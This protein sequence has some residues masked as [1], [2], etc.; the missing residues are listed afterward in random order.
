MV[1]VRTALIFTLLL[2][3]AACSRKTEGNPLGAM[4][5]AATNSTQVFIVKGV[6]KAVK[7]GGKIMEIRHETIPDYMPAMTMPFDVKNPNEV[8]NLKPGDAISF[9]LTATDTDSWIDQ[10]QKIDAA[11]NST[12]STASTNV[13]G[14]FRQVADV[15]PLQVGDPLPE[16]HFTNELGQPVS[17]AQFKGE[18][19]AITFIF[20]RCPLPNFCPRMSG[21]FE[22]AQQLLLT[23][24][25]AGTNWHLLTI[26]FD[27]SFDTPAVLKSYATRYEADPKHWNFLTGDLKDITAIS[28]QFGQLFWQDEGSLNHNLRTAVIDASGKVQKLFQGNAWTPEDLVAEIVK[29]TKAR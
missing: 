21:N 22:K 9:R 8:L 26:S 4:A 13:I 10:I 16:Y 29:A 12:P 7:P 14:G 28:T 6:V 24:A 11:T 17:T 19:L 1:Y 15:D 25:V 27:P 23:N 18:A 2:S 3:L 5:S 20:T